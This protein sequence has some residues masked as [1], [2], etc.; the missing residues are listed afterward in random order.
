MHWKL[1]SRRR[2][3]GMDEYG[4]M[5]VAEVVFERRFEAPRGRIWRALTDPAELASWL[6]PAEMDMRVGGSVVL[7]FEERDERGTITEL[8]ELEVIAYTWNEG[9]TNS[10]VRF[11][12]ETDGDGTRLR[13]QH[14]FDGEVDLSSYGGGWHHHLEQLMAQV[15][16]EPITWDSNR[17]KELK[18]EYELKAV[19]RREAGL[20]KER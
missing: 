15:A 16:G 11:E 5:G 13:L 3:R 19:Q 8:R 10:L 6:A 20:A 18:S 12:L 7:T 9:K 1:T 4:K 17:Y 14:T 2:V